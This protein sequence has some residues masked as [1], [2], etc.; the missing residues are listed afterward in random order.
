MS[1]NKIQDKNKDNNKR[2]DKD[3]DKEKDEGNDRDEGNDN[4]KGKDK[5]M[6]NDKDKN[7]N[8]HK[9]KDKG[10]GD[11]TPQEKKKDLNQ[12]NIR[13]KF[14]VGQRKLKFFNKGGKILGGVAGAVGGALNVAS[15]GMPFIA[16]G[17][18][19]GA[20][21]GV[22]MVNQM[23]SICDDLGA[24]HVCLLLGNDIFEYGDKGY[25]RHKNVGKT[26]EYD[27]DNNFEIEG[28]TKVSPD[29]LEAKINENKE[30][31]ADNYDEITHN[32]H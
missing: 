22:N 24:V 18:I 27:W 17:M 9:R 3:K 12:K 5:E 21:F 32:C 15:L 11:Y 23:E 13:Y 14:T 2:K 31:I 20:N 7:N 1:K 26:S 6:E 19:I 10:K 16:P 30:W 28:E 25:F 29:E 8:L 4:D